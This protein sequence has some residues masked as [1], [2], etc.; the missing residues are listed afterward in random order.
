M[1]ENDV[2][3][4]PDY[5]YGYRI[6][7]KL[8]SAIESRHDKAV[9]AMRRAYELDP[10]NPH[11]ASYNAA[12]HWRLGDYENTALWMNH[13]ARQVPGSDEARV[14]RA[15]A[16]ISGA[17]FENAR[18]ELSRC[19]SRNQ[20]YWLAVFTLARVDMAAGHPQDAIDR[21]TPEN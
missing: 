21:C 14:Y 16:Y 12:M 4:H 2:A 5:A 10:G 11:N 19:V 17:D 13:A 6:L 20:L 8:Y 3:G 15:W 1:L 7:G 18:R 9:K